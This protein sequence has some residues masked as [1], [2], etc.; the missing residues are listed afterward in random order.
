[1]PTTKDPRPAPQG[2]KTPA[3]KPAPYRFTDFAAI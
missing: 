2:P 3:P 1:M